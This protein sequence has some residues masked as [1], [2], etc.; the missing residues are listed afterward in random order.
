MIRPV[1]A[2]RIP[3]IFFKF[4]DQSAPR[5]GLEG[6]GPSGEEARLLEKNAA[7]NNV[8][9]ALRTREEGVR[10]FFVSKAPSIDEL[11]ERLRA[12]DEEA[13]CQLYDRFADQL[14]RLAEREIGGRLHK[15]YGPED[16]V[17]SAMGSFLVR[18]ADGEYQFDHSGAIWKLLTTVLQN[19]IRKKVDY[20]TAQKRDIQREVPF[21][22]GMLQRKVIT[23]EEA[24]ELADAFA[25]VLE[26]LE[27]RDAQ[28]AQLWH[29]NH[30]PAEIS[31]KVGCSSSTVRRM[32]DRIVRMLRKAFGG[33]GDR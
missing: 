13:A 6:R 20:Y 7:A 30:T 22:S 4:L 23:Q 27:P 5:I 16:A 1:P 12:G 32:L 19:K 15:R 17:Q 3:V 9:T 25:A 2:R 14:V 8:T 29:Q 26:Q 21:D 11:L 31:E 18:V 33:D 24:I 28:I 10:I